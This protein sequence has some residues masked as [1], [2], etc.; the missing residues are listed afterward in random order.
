MTS[1]AEHASASFN[2]PPPEPRQ[3]DANSFPFHEANQPSYSGTNESNYMQNAPQAAAPEAAPGDTGNPFFRQ[4]SSIRPASPPPPLPVMP[5]EQP[6]NPAAAYDL[7]QL[8]NYQQAAAELP[9]DPYAE[10]YTT[11]DPRA[12]QDP[13]QVPPAPAQDPYMPPTGQEPAQ[14]PQISD[15]EDEES[16]DTVKSINDALRGLFR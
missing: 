12:N 15:F 4:V 3:Q 2:A 5:M 11:Q 9:Y 14:P 13:Y 16:D 10:Q 7:Q 8:A 6:Q 1:Q